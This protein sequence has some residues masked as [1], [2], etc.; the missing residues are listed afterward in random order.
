MIEIVCWCQQRYRVEWLVDICG[1][2]QKVVSAIV[3]GSTVIGQKWITLPVGVGG[4]GWL[5]GAMESGD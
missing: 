2:D 4:S 5:S 1:L 3:S